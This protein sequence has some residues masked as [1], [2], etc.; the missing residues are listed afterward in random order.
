MMYLHGN[1]EKIV[2]AT[3]AESYLASVWPKTVFRASG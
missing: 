2:S 3:S 1:T